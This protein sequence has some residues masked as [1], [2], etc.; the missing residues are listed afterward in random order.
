M[1][2]S[3]NTAKTRTIPGWPKRASV[4]GLA[5]E[6]VAG[7]GEG[8]PA[9]SG[10]TSTAVPSRRGALGE[11]LLDRH[12]ALE[13]QVGGGVGDAEATPA[14]HPTHLEATAVQQRALGQL[15]GHHQPGAAGP[16]GQPRVGDGGAA[17]GA[18]IVARGGRASGSVARRPRFVG[19]VTALPNL[20]LGPLLGGHRRGRAG[21]PSPTC[22]RA[23][24]ISSSLNGRIARSIAD[25]IVRAQG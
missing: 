24:T 14:E 15:G 8:R 19:S 9:S 22:S 7:L 11:Q 16:A 17:R 23:S 12:R 21:R 6:P 1:P 10:A 18:S 3:S 25:Q 4:R 13:P 5:Q 20:R 2:F